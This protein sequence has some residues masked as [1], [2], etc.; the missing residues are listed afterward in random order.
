MSAD[1]VAVAPHMYRVVLEN[2]RVRVLEARA[3]PG[4]RAD[5]HSHPAGVAITIAGAQVRVTLGDGE[6]T[7]VEF[8]P[9]EVRYMEP[10]EHAGEVVGPGELRMLIIE[11]K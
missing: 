8:K 4:D 7:E 9:N 2:D 10:I 11:L 3:K 6:S 5:M 1:A